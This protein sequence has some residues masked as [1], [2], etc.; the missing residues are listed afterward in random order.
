MGYAPW[1]DASRGRTQ[2]ASLGTEHLPDA[3]VNTEF[4]F[5][6]D[7]QTGSEES[8][9]GRKMGGAWVSLNFGGR[10]NPGDLTDDERE[11]ILA[12]VQFALFGM[13]TR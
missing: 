13:G 5:A 12:A 9:P 1:V 11:Y 3:V 6:I 10:E 2:P 8:R 7:C 4:L